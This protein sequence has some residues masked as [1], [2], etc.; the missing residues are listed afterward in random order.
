MTTTYDPRATNQVPTPG[1]DEIE[2]PGWLPVAQ[3]PFRL[4]RFDHRRADGTTLDLHYT[5]EG[6]GPV[7]VFVHA[8]LWSFIWR[9]V[10]AALRHEFRCITLDFPGAGL[11]G[12]D[13]RD[14][15]L[16]TYPAVLDALLDHLEVDCAGEGGSKGVATILLE[17]LGIGRQR[18]VRRNGETV[19]MAWQQKPTDSDDTG[20]TSSCQRNTSSEAAHRR[21]QRDVLTR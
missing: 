12:G 4:R 17:L 13:R 1:T 5:D 11:S 3:W 16:S 21:T 18:I 20:E 15:D 9:D 8:G 14:V 2:R 19:V 6:S 7:L 10:L